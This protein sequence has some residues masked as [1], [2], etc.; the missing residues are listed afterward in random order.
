MS[1]DLVN[2]VL[3][4]VGNISTGTYLSPVQVGY[5]HLIDGTELDLE[6]MI[7]RRIQLEDINGAF[8]AM[9]AGEVIRSVIEF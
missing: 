7:T 5:I 4:P 6:G 9:Q 2:S 3:V 1:R 8:R